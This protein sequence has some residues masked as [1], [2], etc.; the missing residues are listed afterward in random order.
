[1][2]TLF[3]QFNSEASI[4]NKEQE[5]LKQYNDAKQ[6]IIVIEEKTRTAADSIISD[7]IK[8]REETINQLKADLKSLDQKLDNQL[9]NAGIKRE[10]IDYLAALAKNANVGFTL[11]LNKIGDTARAVSNRVEGK[12]RANQIS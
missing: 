3:E 4:T 12:I 9:I 10:R 2:K 7:V 11:A 5:I 6:K 1:V 8:H